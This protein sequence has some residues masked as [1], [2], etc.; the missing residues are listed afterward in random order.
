MFFALAACVISM[1][2]MIWSS[3]PRRPSYG[4]GVLR[5]IVLRPALLEF[6]DRNR[7]ITHAGSDVAAGALLS[8]GRGT[9]QD[10]D[11]GRQRQDLCHGFHLTVFLRRPAAPV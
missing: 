6:L 11:D 4:F 3:A 2:A 5:R 1:S 9:R 10:R 7:P 8:G